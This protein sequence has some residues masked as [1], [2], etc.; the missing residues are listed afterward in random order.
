MV[1]WTRGQV[2]EGYVMHRGR[3]YCTE[4]RR[5]YNA[6]LKNVDRAPGLTRPV[7]RRH[8]YSPLSYIDARRATIARYMPHPLTGTIA[9]DLHEWVNSHR[10]ANRHQSL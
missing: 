7:D 5:A 1:P 9:T 3:G 4:C 6:A 2:P 10:Q 8:G